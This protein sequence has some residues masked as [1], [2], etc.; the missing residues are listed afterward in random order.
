MEFPKLYFNHLIKTEDSSATILI[1]L[2]VSFVFLPEGIQKLIFPTLL[3]SG[4]FAQIGI[5]YPDVMGPFVG[6]TEITCGLLILLG[7]AT[8]FAAI[9]LIIIMI[10]AII[11]T[12][13]PILLG[14][15]W[16]LFQ[17]AKFSRYGFW[18]MMHEIRTDMCM[19]LASIYLLIRGGGRW[20][21]DVWISSYISEELRTASQ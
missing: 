17:V 3:G 7:L 19:L 2:L 18:S 14:H 8:R 9:P 10:V 21:V 6:I 20:S 11:A 4:R 12:K 1:R 16:W 13:I 5:P 15:D